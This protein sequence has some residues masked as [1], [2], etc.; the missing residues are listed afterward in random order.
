MDNWVAGMAGTIALVGTFVFGYSIGSI[1]IGNDC[2]KLGAFY[3]SNTVYECKVKE[4][5]E[6]HGL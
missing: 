2:K 3:V 5:H 1:D 6:Q 4:K